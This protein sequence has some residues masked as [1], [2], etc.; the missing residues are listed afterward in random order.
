M[1]LSVHPQ[2]VAEHLFELQQEVKIPRLATMIRDYGVWPRH[3][4]LAVFWLQVEQKDRSHEFRA[5]SRDALPGGIAAQIKLDDGSLLYVVDDSDF[6]DF[7][8]HHAWF[9]GTRSS[10]HEKIE[11]VCWEFS[12]DGHSGSAER[13]NQGLVE[14]SGTRQ[15]PF[16]WRRNHMSSAR[17][18]W[19]YCAG[20][21]R[22]DH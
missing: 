7:I 16:L 18:K 4:P 15:A 13:Y 11:C 9:E 22:G 5:S 2:S 17:R 3:C 1:S 19:H 6:T 20:A 14:C 8:C 12:Q 21:G 10:S